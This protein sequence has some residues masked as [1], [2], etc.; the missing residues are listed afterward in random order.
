MVDRNIVNKLGLTQEKLE[1]QVNEM[2]GDQETAFLEE[3]LQ[4]S[5]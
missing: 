2:F 1:Q 5:R 4:T 3:A